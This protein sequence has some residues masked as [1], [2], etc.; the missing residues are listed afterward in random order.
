[1]YCVDVSEVMK[2]IK[3]TGEHCAEVE[4]VACPLITDFVKLCFEIDR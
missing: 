3:P 1:M 2:F 4:V